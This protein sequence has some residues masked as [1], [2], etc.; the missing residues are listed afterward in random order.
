VFLELHKRL[1]DRFRIVLVGT[2]D[3]VDAGLPDGIISI[4][5]TQN[6]AELAEI[7]SAADLLFNPTREENYPTVHME[8]LA[9]GT[10]VLSFATGGCAEMLDEICGMTVPKNDVDAAERAIRHIQSDRPFAKENCL[11]KAQ[12]FSEKDRFEEYTRLYE[13]EDS[14]LD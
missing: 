7:Y 14:I 5:R 6:Q 1:D 4:H 3:E 11:K 8:S 12:A 9:C 13:V 10:P 2:N